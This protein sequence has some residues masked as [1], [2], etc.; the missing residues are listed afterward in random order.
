MVA[1]LRSVVVVLSAGQEFELSVS[2]SV[3]HVVDAAAAVDV[4]FNDAGPWLALE[5]GLGLRFSVGFESVRVRSASAQ[6]VR[7][8]VGSADVV[9]A[10]TTL[11]PG[12]VVAVAA[13]S[14]FAVAAVVVG[15]AAVQLL[16]T[17]VLRRSALVQCVS[18]D[19]FVGAGAGV[20]AANGVRLSAGESLE[21]GSSAAVWAIGSAAARDVRVLEVLS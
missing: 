15:T 14:S 16:A 6:T 13:G 19:V 21:L 3:L 10:R 12:A 9:D 17:N 11:T 8:L 1:E 5:K 20:T 18:G 2:G 7:L 4:M